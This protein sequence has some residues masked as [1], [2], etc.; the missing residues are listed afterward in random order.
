[1]P[2]SKTILSIYL[3]SVTVIRFKLSSFLPRKLSWDKTMMQSFAL[4]FSNIFSQLDNRNRIW[5]AYTML[6][7][8][9]KND[10]RD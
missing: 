1:M 7:E 5:K 10:E 6:K 8:S 4:E 9:H 2:N 3:I